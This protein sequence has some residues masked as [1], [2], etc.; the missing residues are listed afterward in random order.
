MPERLPSAQA[1][2]IVAMTK[3]SFAELPASTKV[4]LY[5]LGAVQFALLGAAHWDISH[6]DPSELRGSKAK[7]RAISLINFVGPIW[8]FTRGRK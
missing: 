7:W 1:T 5:L 8:Y 4:L 3:K 2:T 6:R